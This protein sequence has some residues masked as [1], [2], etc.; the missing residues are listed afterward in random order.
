MDM[1]LRTKMLGTDC[2]SPSFSQSPR[3]LRSWY[4][5]QNDPFMGSASALLSYLK[6]AV[7]HTLSRIPFTPVQNSLSLSLSCSRSSFEFLEVIQS[8]CSGAMYKWNQQTIHIF[9][10]PT[11]ATRLNFMQI[12]SIFCQP[13]WVLFQTPSMWTSFVHAPCHPSTTKAVNCWWFAWN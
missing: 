9:G 4:Q 10:P 3:I 12:I 8:L 11:P 7:N 13:I 2:W 1:S 6:W 5:R